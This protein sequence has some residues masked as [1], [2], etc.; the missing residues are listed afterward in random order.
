MN[1][2]L[3][4]AVNSITFGGLLFL[5]SAGFSLIFG[6]MRIPNLTHGSLFMLGAYV[7]VTFVIG[8]HGFQLNFWLA[9]ILATLSVAALGAL[10]ERLLLRRMPGDQLA[11]VL[12]TLGL[13]FM[14]ADLCLMVW[15]GDPISVPTPPELEGFARFGVLVF[16]AYRLAIIV[17]AILFA[18]ALWLLLDRTRLGAM[19]RAG[20]DDPDMA[21]VEPLRKR[22]RADVRGDTL[23]LDA[24]ATRDSEKPQAAEKPR[25]RKRQEKNAVSEWAGTMSARFGRV[26]SKGVAAEDVDVEARLANGRIT[27]QTADA[28]VLGGTV[29]LAGTTM[30]LGAPPRF[31]VATAKQVGL[32]QAAAVAEKS[33]RLLSGTLGLTATLSGQGVTADDLK[34][35]IDGRI[36]LSLDDGRLNGPDLNAAIQKSL[37]GSLAKSAVGA[38][39]STDGLESV[40]NTKLGDQRIRATISDGWATLDKPV[41]LNLGVGAVQVDG[42]VAL[43][44]RLDLR[45]TVT[46]APAFVNA[47][48]K[49]KFTPG[50]PID[51]PLELGGSTSDPK[52][53]VD[54]GLVASI[55]KGALGKDVGKSLKDAIRDKFPGF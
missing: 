10:A 25:E 42:R 47:L 29:D 45:G 20:V 26:V 28:Q 41:R 43:D 13:S 6:L 23:D 54:T 18:V 4:L 11:Q 5:L 22:F 55:A 53:S 24:F 21:R 8:I 49:G 31:E 39:I 33:E 15:G 17:I 2:W 50:E 51:V 3:V 52:V 12:V 36:A 16:P 27:L 34:H 30:Q 32:E 9:A 46:L 48:T 7:G 40:G 44:K 14:A 1:F 37:T 35:G 38:V 19:I